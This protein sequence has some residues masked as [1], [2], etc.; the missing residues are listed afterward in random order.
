LGYNGFEDDANRLCDRAFVTGEISID[1]FIAAY[2]KLI[3]K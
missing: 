1:E 3:T 2:Q